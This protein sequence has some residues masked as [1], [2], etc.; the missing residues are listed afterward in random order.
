M[1]YTEKDKSPTGLNEFFATLKDAHTEACK[2]GQY[3]HQNHW[4]WIAVAAS[5]IDFYAQT[6]NSCNQATIYG[7]C[8]AR[9]DKELLSE[10]GAMTL[11]VTDED[12]NST[13]W[14]KDSLAS[15]KAM[16]SAMEDVDSYDLK[17]L[18]ALYNDMQS[19][20]AENRPVVIGVL[21]SDFIPE[22]AGAKAHAM[23]I[24]G[25]GAFKDS[26]DPCWEIWDPWKGR[27]LYHAPTFPAY[28][29]GDPGAK[30]WFANFTHPPKK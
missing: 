1:T 28:F 27:G 7:D 25:Y 10:A 24:T 11:P 19:E 14:P 9:A 22:L 2:Y 4:C 30:L 23:V 15:V 6:R 8:I 16:G 20:L 18:M 26:S 12:N 21:F 5:I 29:Y 17:R 13:G 3:Q